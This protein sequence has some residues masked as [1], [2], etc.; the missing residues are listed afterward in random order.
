MQM[1]IHWLLVYV[2]MVDVVVNIS[3]YGTVHSAK[4]DYSKIQRFENVKSTVRNIVLELSEGVE[5]PSTDELFLMD[6]ILSF[7]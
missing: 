2:P 5:V 6:K 4:W 3:K 1:H 7:S